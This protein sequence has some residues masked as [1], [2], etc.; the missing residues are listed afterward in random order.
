VRISSPFESDRVGCSSLAMWWSC[1]VETTHT[2]ARAFENVH[3]HVLFLASCVQ[4]APTHQQV[5]G[6]S[7][8]SDAAGEAAGA[9]AKPL[10]LQDV[11]Q[12]DDDG[13]DESQYQS[14]FSVDSFR[15]CFAS[16]PAPAP[17]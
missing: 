10:S 8:D 1:V 14:A 5:G 11:V 9:S 12:Q 16:A 4:H 7:S 3:S 15:E 13:W 2:R 6:D 17:L